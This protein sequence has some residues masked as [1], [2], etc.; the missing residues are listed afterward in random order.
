MLI[1][2]RGEGCYLFDTNGNRY[3]DGISSLWVNAHGH[4]VPEIDAAIREQLDK[5]AHS[6]FLGQSNV[7]ASLFAAELIKIAPKGLTRV[8]YSDS[9]A[10]A[11]EIAL[12]MAFQ[13]HR[14]NGNPQR[15]KFIALCDAYHGDTIGSVSVGGIATFH[16]IFEPLLFQ[17]VRVHTP[18]CY[19]C[20]F[21]CEP[22]TCSKQCFAALKAAFDEHGP[23][24]AA[25]VIEPRVQGAA[26]MIVHPPGYLKLME[27]LCKQHGV[28]LIA[29]E[30]AVGFGRTG[31]MFAC[32]AEDVHPDFLCLGKCIT[33]GYLPLAATLATEAV[34]DGFKGAVDSN[35]A[36]YHGHSYTGN[37]LASAAALANL[38]LYSDNSVVERVR[39]KAILLTSLLD[40]FRALD[41]VGDIRQ[42]GF[43]VGIELVAD[44]RTKRS[45]NKKDRVS[46]KVIRA[47]RQ[48][49]AILRPL[50]DVIVLMPPLA[51][52]NAELDTLVSIIYNSICE[53]V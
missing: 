17:V 45:L 21:D 16:S 11:V 10:E 5:I 53:I 34:F 22:S 1:I 40:K 52:S 7:P 48:R 47:A 2:E 46:H 15:A 28:F 38:R 51:I 39:E 43:M 41:S 20:P 19:R 25:A 50:G 14:Q 4:R 36:F 33:G 26:G 9:G 37:Q 13:F 32:E 23:S 27:T 30:V 6:T 29:D 18:H 35:R 31:Y 12:K 3:L 44:K 49:G 42:C 24:L 8:F